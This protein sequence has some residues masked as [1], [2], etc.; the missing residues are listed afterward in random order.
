LPLH[1]KSF[2]GKILL[3]LKLESENL[4]E[5]LKSSDVIDYNSPDIRVLAESLSEGIENEIEL[6]GKFTNMSEMK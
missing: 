3:E 6:L 4:K 1:K 5:Y 2:G